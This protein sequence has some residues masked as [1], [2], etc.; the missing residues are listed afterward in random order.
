[1][2]HYETIY[3]T[4]PTLSDE[5]YK[6]VLAKFNGIVER[7]KGVIIKVDE[8]GKQKLAYLLK[9][10]DRGSYIL[11]EYCGDPGMTK[12][13]ERELK[14]DDRILK[15]Q[16]V[17]LGDQVNPEDLIIKDEKVE[18]T[19]PAAEGQEAEAQG[20]PDQEST[21]QESTSPENEGQESATQ[22]DTEQAEEVKDGVQ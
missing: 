19:S 20:S 16:T 10:F 13:F 21:G 17:K 6:E 22:Q 15:F 8:W 12:E 11:V 1:M 4:N 18:E 14:L 9:K 7:E 5:G 3:I 2:R